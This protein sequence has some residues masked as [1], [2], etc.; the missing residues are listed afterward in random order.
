MQRVVI[1]K[2]RV[3]I[4]TPCLSHCHPPP[5]PCKVLICEVSQSWLH[6][7]R[8]DAT[9]CSG[10][11]DIVVAVEHELIVESC[12]VSI[13]P[14]R[15]GAAGEYLGLDG[16]IIASRVEDSLSECWDLRLSELLLWMG[17]VDEVQ[18]ERSC[19]NKDGEPRLHLY[20]LCSEFIVV[21]LIRNT[22]FLLF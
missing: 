15:D 14:V 17:D 18:Q 11:I 22:T 8:H 21:M 16:V 4:R 6:S 13:D 3:W 1:S 12:S 9:V 20:L 10:E 7:G 2:F 5:K 19:R